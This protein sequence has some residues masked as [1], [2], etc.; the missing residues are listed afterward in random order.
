MQGPELQ[1]LVDNV[2]KH[3][4]KLQYMDVHGII[5]LDAGTQVAMTEAQQI[6]NRE[7]MKQEQEAAMKK[8]ACPGEVGRLMQQRLKMYGFTCDL[9]EHGGTAASA[10][11][12]QQ[13]LF[14]IDEEEPSHSITE[15]SEPVA[16]ITEQSSPSGPGHHYQQ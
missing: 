3:E 5:L 2:K 11:A 15:I 9:V 6:K 1:A 4:D 16:S 13:D 7:M 14:A 12:D 10:Q 8:H